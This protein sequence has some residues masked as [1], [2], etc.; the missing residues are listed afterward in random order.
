MNRI[1]LLLAAASLALM[2]TGAASASVVCS[3]RSCDEQQIG[4]YVAPEIEAPNL[5]DR[6]D[7]RG[8]PVPVPG[9]QGVVRHR[10][11]A[12][13]WLGEAPG[14]ANLF[15]NPGRDRVTLDMKVDFYGPVTGP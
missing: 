3:E 9:L 6:F 11:G 15:L 2:P 10:P 1:R 13:V 5:E 7:P 12:G 8:R 14:N 4:P